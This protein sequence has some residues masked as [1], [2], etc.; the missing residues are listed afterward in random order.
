MN[1][2]SKFCLQT[3]CLWPECFFCH[4][5]AA[6]R[7]E[8]GVGRR[9]SHWQYAQET[10]QK[11]SI[12][13]KGLRNLTTF[14]SQIPLHQR[15]GFL[16]IL[17][18]HLFKKKQYSSSFPAKCSKQSTPRIRN[19]TYHLLYSR[20]CVNKGGGGGGK[21]LINMKWKILWKQNKKR[22]RN[23][24]SGLSP[25]LTQISFVLPTKI[26]VFFFVSRQRYTL[27]RCRAPEGVE[28]ELQG[29]NSQ[30]TIGNLSVGV[31]PLPK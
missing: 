16:H 9:K 17:K 7:R 11:S 19:K 21:R 31:L 18:I 15:M 5:F 29:R 6:S 26:C 14:S 12:N 3:C 23:R 30:I 20:Y 28:W 10:R 1:T 4:N 27:G 22:E 25:T 13:S 8:G 24:N 2:L